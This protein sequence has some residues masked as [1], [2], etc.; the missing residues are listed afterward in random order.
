MFATLTLGLID[1]V[2]PLHFA[3]RLSQAGIGARYA[4]TALV[5]A[6]A[7][8]V[9]ARWAPR[10]VL[11]AALGAVIL[12]VAAAGFTA[13]VPLWIAA[14]AITATGVGLANTGSVGAL[15]ESVPTER[16]V[17]AMVI[18]SQIGIV[19]YLIGPLVGGPVGRSSGFG[20]LAGVAAVAALPCGVAPARYRAARCNPPPAPSVSRGRV[21]R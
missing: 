6:G 3:E 8:A 11:A 7:A 21:A 10:R 17:M 4:A 1:G 13:T 2:L 16:I 18:W 14:L 9:A 12:G 19:G 5:L 15:L 20:A